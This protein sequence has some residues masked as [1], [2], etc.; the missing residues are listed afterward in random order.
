[1]SNVT[2][3]KVIEDLLGLAKIQ[4]GG[5]KPWDIHVH[6]DRFYSR[7]L[8]EGTLG[9]GESY[10]DKWWDCEQLDDFFYR[11]M[12]AELHTKV[13]QKGLIWAILK[14]KLINLQSKK[15]ALADIQ[16]HYD[17]GNDLFEKMLDKRMVYSCGYWREA[18][19]LDQAQEAKL[20]LVCQKVGLK[21]GMKVLDIGCGWG[22][23][24]QFAADRYQVEVVGVTLSK[25]QVK[26]GRAR[27]KDYPIEIRLQD[28]R[29]VAGEFDRIVSI[30]MFEHVGPQ[31]HRT[32]MKKVADLLKE[33]GL[34][35]LHTIGS[36]KAI[37]YPEPWSKKYIFPHAVLPSAKQIAAASEPYF[38]F[39]DWHNFGVDYDKTLLAWHQNFKQSWPELQGAYDE[40]FKRMW[41]YYL[42]HNAGAGARSRKNQLWQIVFAKKG[43][44]GGYH[45]IR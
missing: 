34:F 2:A 5:N 32:F 31:N 18:E 45:S 7:V 27:C 42:L 40:R 21:P 10:M 37:R 28:Y 17:T 30:G 15:R 33:E 39:E 23:F 14:A 22:S 13:R 1:M 3:R 9:L 6:D 16:W 41:E 29:D 25:E 12:E 24:A 19:N 44:K 43:V 8:A 36:K 38:M 26:L 11:I 4:I 20:D 35:L